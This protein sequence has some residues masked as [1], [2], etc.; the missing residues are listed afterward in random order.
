[1]TVGRYARQLRQP[2]TQYPLLRLLS[3]REYVRVQRRRGRLSATAAD[4]RLAQLQ[5]DERVALE[6][7]R[8]TLSQYRRVTQD[9]VARNLRVDRTMVNKVWNSG[10]P[11][12]DRVWI[13]SARIIAA[14]YRALEAE[15]WS[16]A[17]VEVAS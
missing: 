6:A 2:I 3:E 8:A 15:G 14:T 10:R 7:L 13:R 17:P 4:A 12:R 5:T 9:R 1:M 16:P 11:G